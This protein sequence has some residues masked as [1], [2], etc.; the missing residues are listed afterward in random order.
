M[1]RR[2]TGSRLARCRSS[3]LR[4]LTIASSS[5]TSGAPGTWPTNRKWIWSSSA[6]AFAVAYTTTSA[7]SRGELSNTLLASTK[8]SKNAGHIFVRPICSHSMSTRSGAG[9]ACARPTA[10]TR[11][12]IVR[13]ARNA[14]IVA[15]IAAAS[16]CGACHTEP[17]RRAPFVPLVFAVAGAMACGSS[18]PVPAR[19]AAPAVVARPAVAAPTVPAPPAIPDTAAGRMLAAWLDA[20]NSGD[21]VRIKAFVERYK[22]PEGLV[23]INNRERTGGFD[24]VAI[25]HSEPRSVT[26]VVREKATATPTIGWLRVADGDPARIESFTVVPIPSGKT[27]ADIH[28][29]ID[30]ATKA[31]IVDAAAKALDAA[32]VYPALAKQ[33]SRSIRDHL[34]HGDDDAITNGPA[35]ADALTHPLDGVSHDRHVRVEWQALAPPAGS[36]EPTADEAARAKQEFEK[37]NCGFAKTERLDGH[38]G[39]IK[40]D[41]FG[42]ADICGP[43]ATAAYAALGDVA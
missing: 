13:T 16:Q 7:P 17:M 2:K 42:P 20:F 24:L 40:L 8:P 30:A 23:M 22:P 10:P 38:I 6:T 41:V 37:M 1:P 3:V 9:W 29:E 5:T 19:A 12:N 11:S 4:E 26:F 36:T 21:A 32:Y 27:A 15:R 31:R 39:Y 35:F 25:E 33:M 28:P 18:R 43:R 14:R 34:A